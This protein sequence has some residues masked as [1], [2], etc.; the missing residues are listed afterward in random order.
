V[1]GESRDRVSAEIQFIRLELA[2]LEKLLDELAEALVP[3]GK[4]SVELR[5]A[6]EKRRGE[7][8][9]GKVKLA[10]LEEGLK[11]EC[12]VWFKRKAKR[13]RKEK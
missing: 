12:G 8:V 2:S 4:L 11:E 7:I 6:L 1:A 5:E 9:Q 3:Q 13:Q 10:S